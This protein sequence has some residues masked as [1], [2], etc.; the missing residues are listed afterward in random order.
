M[1]PP[2]VIMPSAWDGWPAEWWPPAWGGRVQSL[3]DLAWACIDTN[4]RALAQ[5]PPYLVGAAPTIDAGWLRNPDPDLYFSWENF[6]KQVF[7]DWYAAGEVFVVATARYSTGWPARFHVLP[8]WLVE[9]D[10]D[11]GLRRYRIGSSEVPAGDLLHLRYQDTTA[12]ARGH[13]PLEAGRQTIIGAEVLGQVCEHDRRQRPDPARDS[14]VAGGDEPRPGR[15]AAGRLGRAADVSYPGYPAVLRGGLKWTPTAMNPKDMALVEL[16]QYTDSKIAVLLG[17][18]PPL[19]GLPTAGDSLTYNTVLMA[20]EQ[21]WRLGLRPSATA[22]MAGLSEWLLPRG[23]TVELNAD[24]YVQPEPKVRAET[25][26]IYNG[27]VDPA[28]GTSVL[29]VDEIREAERL[30]DTLTARESSAMAGPV[31]AP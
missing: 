23:T 10:M 5:M 8:P 14:G 6:V 27:I 29:S 2:S 31:L 18:P 19:V 28:T 16:S 9:V 24:A 30:E 17:V 22:V 4:A 11:S 15:H 26:A 3:T 21:H 13:G 12:D 25:A 1:A 7:W 20:L